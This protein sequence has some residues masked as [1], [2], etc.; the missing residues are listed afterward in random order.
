MDSTANRTRLRH[1]DSF[2]DEI[3]QRPFRHGRWCRG[4]GREC[5]ACREHAV[6]PKFGRRDRRSFRQFPRAAWIENPGAADG[7]ALRKCARAGWL[8]GERTE[9]EKGWLAW[10]N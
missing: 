9:G 1:G 5:R 3:S 2:G 8:A 4:G 6:S 10:P 7:T